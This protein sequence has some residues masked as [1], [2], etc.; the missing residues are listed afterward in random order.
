MNL[1]A[2]VALFKLHNVVE[3]C[4][5][6]GVDALC[7]VADGHDLVVASQL[8]NDVGLQT[9]SVL[10]LVDK[11]VLKTVLVLP[12]NLWVLAE[13]LQEV[14]QQ[15]IVIDYLLVELCLHVSPVELIDL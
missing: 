11:N 13:E 10:K 3:V 5:A 2:W 7:V 12:T 1:S 15:I 8:V 9:V 14:F 6:P 4:A